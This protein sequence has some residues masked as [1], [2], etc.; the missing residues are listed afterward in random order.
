MINEKDEMTSDSFEEYH[1]W[2]GLFVEE[3]WLEMFCGGTERA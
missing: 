3:R 2:G 1:F